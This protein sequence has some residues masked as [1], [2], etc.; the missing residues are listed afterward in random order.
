[1]AEGLTYFVSDLH[2]RGP[3]DRNQRLFLEFLDR[4]V[5]STGAA[6]VVA[7]D[8]FDFWYGLPERVPAP[9]VEVID[10]LESL[11]SVVYLEGNHDVRL[12]RA[13]G[14]DSRID[15]VVGS[16]RMDVGS[17]TVHVEHGD[18]VDSAD[19]GHMAFK[20]LMLSRPAAVVARALGERALQWVG[21]TAAVVSRGDE[22]GVLGQNPRWLAAAREFAAERA[23]EGADLTILG[24]GHW[25]GWWSD[26]LVC[27]GDWLVFHSYLRVDTDGAS[28]CRF[29]QAGDDITVATGPVGAIPPN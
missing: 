16:R 17:L 11:P 14:P 13:L 5:R 26:S 1:M 28:L 19:V 22:D 15:V 27:L 20:R 2:L 3:E 8:L 7:G 4:R 21:E 25:L 6:L 29:V 24:H 18:H 10:A 23:S 12:G 9:F